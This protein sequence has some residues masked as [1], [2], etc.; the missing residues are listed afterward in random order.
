MKLQQRYADLEKKYEVATATEQKCD[1]FSS[2]ILSVVSQLY[3][4]A[5]YRYFAAVTCISRFINF[6]S[7][8]SDIQ[9]KTKEQSLYGHRFVLKSRNPSWSTLSNDLD[10]TGIAFVFIFPSIAL[11]VNNAR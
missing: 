9:I 8:F 1:T 4:C 5:Q 7:S 6:R 10:L 2:R 11:H 3:N